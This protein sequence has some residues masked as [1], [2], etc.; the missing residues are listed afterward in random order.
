MF[1]G[2]VTLGVIPDMSSLSWLSSNPMSQDISLGAQSSSLPAGSA[3]SMVLPGVGN[4]LSGGLPKFPGGSVSSFVGDGL[5]PFPEKL[6]RKITELSFIEM[7]ELLPEIWMAVEEEATASNVLS[8]PRRKAAPITDI[9]LW[10]Q[11]FANYVAVLSVR[12]PSATPDLL[13][14]MST[15]IKCARDYDG[16]AWAQYDRNYRKSMCQRKDLRWS[17]VNSSLYSLCFNCRNKRVVACSFC[18]SDTH[19]SEQCPDNPTRP[20]FWQPSGF[21]GGSQQP[22]HF[23]RERRVFHSPGAG[24]PKVCFAFNDKEG[25][26]CSFRDCRFAH[27]CDGCR[28][29]HPRSACSGDHSSKNLA[30]DSFTLKRQRRM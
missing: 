5:L 6:I 12:F 4:V 18:L 27:V 23:Q 16:I 2:P 30:R 3:S 9:L 1:V 20:L 11:C 15:I 14:Y 19:S 28:G 25:N 13:T 8:L 24:P 17:H 7:S 29:P 22:Q 21:R 10:A 26:K